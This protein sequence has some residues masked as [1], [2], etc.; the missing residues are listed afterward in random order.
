L[1]KF[2]E[3]PWRVAHALSQL[4][5]AVMAGAFGGLFFWVALLLLTRNVG[6]SA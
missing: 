2:L 6:A 5:M 1:S 3:L 4:P